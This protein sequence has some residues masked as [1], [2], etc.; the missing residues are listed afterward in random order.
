MADW[1]APLP[2][3]AVEGAETHIEDHNA[4]VAAITEARGVIDAA[5]ATIASLQGL[6]DGKAESGHKHAAADITS[7]T[8]DAARIPTLAVGKISGLQ[9]ALDG[10]QASG[11]YAT[12]AQVNAKADQTALDALE[13]RV[14]ALETPEE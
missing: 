13:A 2:E 3:T 11:N 7:G 12:T 8:F 5:E 9:D 4:I 1:T 14:D 6:L 10:K